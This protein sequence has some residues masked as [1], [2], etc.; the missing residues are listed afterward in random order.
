MLASRLCILDHRN[1]I[2]DLD[3][4]H[5]ESSQRESV[6]LDRPPPFFHHLFLTSHFNSGPPIP[7]LVEYK[8]DASVLV[9]RIL[10]YRC[11]ISVRHERRHF[12][13]R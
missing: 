12:F 4:N 10:F 2:F 13:Q 1:R 9:Q 3:D 6:W 8:T 11:I 5:G 7:R